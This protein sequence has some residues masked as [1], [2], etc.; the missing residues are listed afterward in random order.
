M[1]A[2]NR[3]REFIIQ[4]PKLARAFS[5]LPRIHSL[6]EYSADNFRT[7]GIEVLVLDFDGVLAE[8]GS[9]GLQPRFKQ[10]LDQLHEQMGAHWRI[11]LWTNCPSCARRALLRQQ[12]PYLDTRYFEGHS[13]KPHPAGLQALSRTLKIDPSRILVVDDRLGTGILAG[14]LTGTQVVWVTDPVKNIAGQPWTELGFN[15]LRSVERGLVKA[16]NRIQK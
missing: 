2:L 9:L 14:L 11:Y 4:L 1:Q 3:T 5:Y 7:M 12:C 13:K 15:L 6:L 16:L 8:Q 10:W